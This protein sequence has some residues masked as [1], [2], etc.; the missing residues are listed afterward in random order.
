[1]AISTYQEL[2][3]AGANWLHRSDLTARTPEFIAL[4]EAKMSR[5]L[6]TAE[7]EATATLTSTAGSPA[8]ALPSGFVTARRVR[9]NV[10]IT[11]DLPI[12]ALSPSLDYG[13]SGTP[14][15]V[16]IQGSNLILKPS[17]AAAYMLTLDF[18]GKFTPLSS[19]HPTNWI[20]ISHPDVYLYGMLAHSAPFLGADARLTVWAQLFLDAIEDINAADAKKR[21]DN[22]QMRTDV[23]A[24]RGTY[25]INTD[26]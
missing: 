19:E 20:L 11:Q 5:L 8:V 16:S 1:M 14:Q 12:L 10:G 22:I 3:D 25:N 23:P 9:I 2:Q 4:A 7:M 18:L 24:T 15:A 26:Q 13:Q 6:K 21:F 17:P